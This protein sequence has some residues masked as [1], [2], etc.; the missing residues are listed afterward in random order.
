MGHAEMLL[1]VAGIDRGG[2]EELTQRLAAQDWASFPAEERAAFHA[3]WLLSRAPHRF[4]DAQR[5]AL[6]RACGT[7]RA[8]DVIWQVA[9]GNYMTLVADSLRLPLERENAF[10]RPSSTSST[11]TAR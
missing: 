8:I 9:W 10:R 5:A 2:V 11:S 1:A 7:E 6:A 4:D 3:G